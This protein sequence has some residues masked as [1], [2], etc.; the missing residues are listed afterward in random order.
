MFFAN[1][2]LSR[3]KQT[4]L[5]HAWKAAHVIRKLSKHQI[6]SS[7]LQ[8]IAV[9][10]RTHDIGLRMSAQLLLGVCRIYQK[11]SDYLLAD[12]EHAE[13]LLKQKMVKTSKK[14]KNSNN[15]AHPPVKDNTL[16][17][18]VAD[19][20]SSS[21][22]GLDI[23][24][25]V[26]SSGIGG[27]NL[28]GLDDS[29]IGTID[30]IERVRRA[31]PS[32]TPNRPMFDTEA[33][34]RS[35]TPAPKRVRLDSPLMEQPIQTFDIG[36]LMP[37]D[38]N[39]SSPGFGLSIDDL[40]PPNIDYAAMDNADVAINGMSEQNQPQQENMDQRVV[41]QQ[42]QPAQEEEEQVE[43]PRGSTR[44]NSAIVL[45]QATVQSWVQNPPSTTLRRKE[46]VEIDLDDLDNQCFG[47]SY[48]LNPKLAAF[49]R[50]ATN[51]RNQPSPFSLMGVKNYGEVLVNIDLNEVL[52]KRGKEPIYPVEQESHRGEEQH[53]EERFNDVGEDASRVEEQLDPIEMDSLDTFNN[54]IDG[55]Q[56]QPQELFEMAP[57]VVALDID[58][59]IQGNDEEVHTRGMS[60]VST[61]ESL[62]EQ[63]ISFKQWAENTLKDRCDKLGVSRMFLS[64]LVSKSTSTS[65][66]ITQESPYDDIM[67]SL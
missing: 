38:L 43:Q 12:I 41:H 21:I 20:D 47:P 62:P 67:I 64:L 37:N 30:D 11:K 51:V 44:R 27:L 58:E 31:T 6:N 3:K 61:L 23:D 19:I 39:I 36:D 16:L 56:E 33:R 63:S 2:L 32:R 35:T 13:A 57:P 50:R 45:T 24:P 10:I 14:P 40:A 5:L 49:W 28:F 60:I 65:F 54:Q 22:P 18:P 34:S 8:A 52:L 15:T 1:Q 46:E 25:N 42:H 48:I 17:P 29:G 4:L 59:E 66:S 9:E 53:E 7:D 26:L 55:F